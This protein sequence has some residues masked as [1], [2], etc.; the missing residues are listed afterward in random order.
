MNPEAVDEESLPLL[1]DQ[2]DSHEGHQRF[3]PFTAVFLGVVLGLLVTI[4]SAL[5]LFR[6]PP[7]TAV[8]LLPLGCGL[9]GAFAAG[10]GTV[11]LSRLVVRWQWWLHG[12]LNALI[13][14]QLVSSGQEAMLG[15]MS[16]VVIVAFTALCLLTALAG[17]ACY[18][19]L[20][21]QTAPRL[22]PNKQEAAL[23]ECLL[24]RSGNNPARVARLLDLEWKAT[25]S[26]SRMALLKQAI[27]RLERDR[28]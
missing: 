19:H 27:E 15:S 16:A 18:L 23:Y 2:S 10:Y 28:R 25:P 11:A 3:S 7:L 1:S 14:V 6:L 21:R 12:L 4:S 5:T 20:S 13:A 8:P 22:Q 24:R 26:A 17:G 9:L